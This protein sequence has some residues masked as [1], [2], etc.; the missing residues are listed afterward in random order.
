MHKEKVN[1]IITTYNRP[2]LLSK[3]ILSILSQTYFNFELIIIDNFSNYDFFTLIHNFN[4]LRIKGFQNQNNGI[5]SINRNF[6]ISKCNCKYIAFCDD[7]DLWEKDKLEIQIDTFISNPK[8]GLCCTASSSINE[9]E[10]SSFRK[11]TSY[12]LRFFL[13]LNLLPAKYLLILFNYITNSSVVIKKDLID[14]IGYLDNDISIR[15]L[16]DFDYWLRISFISK[17]FFI[18]KKL[19]IYRY[20]DEQASNLDLKLKKNKF[21]EICKKN[22]NNFNLLQKMLLNF[23]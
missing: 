15:Y 23:K 20:H 14:K 1:I 19:V 9:L 2:E 17:I 7:D 5:I 4:D 21:H 10:L 16:E 8:I 3:T 18:N 22:K 12:I 13:G 6:G 11:A